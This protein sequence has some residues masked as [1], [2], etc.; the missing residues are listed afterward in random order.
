MGN[1]SDYS[2]LYSS[3]ESEV[4]PENEMSGEEFSL[5]RKGRLKAKVVGI[6][7]LVICGINTF[8]TV[9]DFSGGIAYWIGGMAAMILLIAV[10][11]MFIKGK[12]GARIALGVIFCLSTLLTLMILIPSFIGASKAGLQVILFGVV[13][14][15][16]PFGINLALIWLTL[17]DKSVKFYCKSKQTDKN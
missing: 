2:S 1:N 6:I 7:Y 16:I 17:F 9:L 13:M 15:I 11:V 14:S 12:N 5:F 3:E 8:K 10:G 4:S